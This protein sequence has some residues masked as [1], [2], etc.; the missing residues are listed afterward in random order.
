MPRNNRHEGKRDHNSYVQLQKK[1]S[2]KLLIAQEQ[3]Q[4]SA[5]KMSVVATGTDHMHIPPS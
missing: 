4:D 3:R 2:E 5:E 1:A